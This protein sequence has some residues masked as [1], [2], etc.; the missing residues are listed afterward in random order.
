MLNEET[1]QR[2]DAW[3]RGEKTDRPMM[4]LIKAR[5]HPDK[6]K[7]IDLQPYYKS[8]KD[9][10]IGPELRV[11][12]TRNLDVTHEFLFEAFNYVDINMGPGS[13]AA[14]LA[15][16][17]QYSRDTVWYHKIETE[18]VRDFENL[19]F[20]KSTKY[21]EEH[22]AAVRRAVELAGEDYFV[23]IPDIIENLDVLA[24][25][26]GSEELCFDLMDDPEGVQRCIQMVDDNY[27]S[28]YDAMYDIVKRK[29]GECCYTAFSI[30]GRD[31]VAKLQCDFSCLMS[32]ASFEEL[33]IPS[34]KKQ[35]DK[36][37]YTLYHLDGKDAIRHVPALMKLDKLNALNWTFGAGQPDA[38]DERWFKIYDQVMDAG[39]SLWLSFCDGTVEQWAGN[40]KKVADRYGNK[41]LYF[42]FP[43]VDEK[44]AEIV[45]KTFCSGKHLFYS[46][47]R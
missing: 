8:D 45:E 36:I 23:C 31:K 47:E 27:F 37:P 5:T 9:L 4:R 44:G 24:S 46:E 12:A 42:H 11:A 40:A 2:F 32:A 18:S 22:L 1:K 43:V 6:S 25:L 39:K 10:H 28:Y 34:L 41:G 33:V 17:P 35:C 21:W 38:A 30:W 3:W 15:A 14:Y 29:N 13:M 19:S 20:K 7:L 16:D 26:R